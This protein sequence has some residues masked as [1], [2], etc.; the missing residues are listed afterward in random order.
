MLFLTSM[1]MLAP[2]IQ[3]QSR[4]NA[5]PVTAAFAQRILRRCSGNDFSHG[6]DIPFLLDT[7]KSP[8]QDH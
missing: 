2:Q 8:V 4:K 5:V 7:A 3:R 6:A 1:G